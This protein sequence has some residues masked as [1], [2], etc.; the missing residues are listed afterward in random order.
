M[1]LREYQIK[2]LNL[3]KE[4]ITLKEKEI[5]IAAAPSSGKTFMMIEFIKA[6]PTKSFLVL[7]HATNVLKTQWADM[8]AMYNLEASLVPGKSR[9]LYGI[10]Q[11]LKSLDLPKYD[12]I[13][14]DEAH[15][16]N[17]IKS[18]KADYQSMVTQIKN[19]TKP[20]NIIY[21]TGTPSKF[22]K[23]G[24][25][26]IIIPAI[27]LINQ[28]FI[29]DV[30]VGMVSTTADLNN[31]NQEG[32]LTKNSIIELEKTVNKDMDSLLEAMVNRLKE[33]SLIKP[34]TNLRKF[35]EWAPTLG[36]LNKTMIACASVIQA[37]KV[38]EYFRTKN[39]SVV[40]ST[41]ENDIDSEN[42]QKFITDNSIKVLVVVQRGILGF[43]M[44][45]L[46]NVVDLTG[47]RNIDRIYQLYARVMRQH[48]SHSYK[49]FFKITD[50]PNRLM[51]QFFVNAS[52]N[53]MFPEFISKYNGKNL[54]GMEIPVLRPKQNK[55]LFKTDKNKSVNK[56]NKNISIDPLFYSTV[57]SAAFL[58]EIRNKAG[59][60]ANEYAMVT[61]AEIREQEGFKLQINWTDEMLQEQ[62]LKYQT[63]KEFEKGSYNAYRAAES[64]GLLNSICNHMKYS[65]LYWTNE[66]IQQAALKYQGRYAFQKGNNKAYEAAKR[67][68]ILNEVCK[69]MD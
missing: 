66:S 35:V 17:F 38:K 36:K 1:E 54:N 9:V 12:Y 57:S 46:V 65:R 31:I 60:I 67:N 49:Y 29:S 63:R 47:S 7:T 55:S 62:A 40:M 56:S 68:K 3:L 39:I 11:G 28:G 24:F 59:S 32:D 14:V 69:H 18:K 5:V 25:N 10:P 19:K 42:I 48:P 52:L 20:S 33:T 64:R 37:E 34:A 23:E 58:Q 27:E 6:N 4:R 26:P 44:P 53:L 61:F 8:F 43:N 16:Y 41:S 22:I 45:E 51:M 50:E 21:L 2:V 30:Y 15:E 13:I